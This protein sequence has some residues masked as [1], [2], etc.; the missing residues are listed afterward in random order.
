MGKRAHP[1]LPIRPQVVDVYPAL[2]LFLSFLFAPQVKN[3]FPPPGGPNGGAA[4]VNKSP[5]SSGYVADADSSLADYLAGAIDRWQERQRSLNS[6]GLSDASESLLA[7]LSNT[8]NA[9]LK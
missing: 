7:I 6:A 4:M 2:F 5:R 9:H 8:L 1:L 3:A